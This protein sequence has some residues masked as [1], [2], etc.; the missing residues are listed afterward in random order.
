MLV[1]SPNERINIQE[2]VYHPWVNNNSAPDTVLQSPRQMFEQVR[3][4][5]TFKKYLIE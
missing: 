2:L 4:T 1:I 5:M 3:L